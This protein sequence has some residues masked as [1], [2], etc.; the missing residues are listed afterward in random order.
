MIRL[1]DRIVSFSFA[2]FLALL[3]HVF[4]GKV[5]LAFTFELTHCLDERGDAIAPTAI[6]LLL[7]LFFL[8]LL[9][10]LTNAI[11]NVTILQIFV[12]F[13]AYLIVDLHPSIHIFPSDGPG[14]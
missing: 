11:G 10:A 6:R 12:N 5:K 13:I 8:L 14:I 9:G 1:I 2:R 7:F 3:L 4:A